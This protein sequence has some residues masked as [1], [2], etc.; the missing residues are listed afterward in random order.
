MAK[1][2][3]SELVQEIFIFLDDRGV[4]DASELAAEMVDELL[5]NVTSLESVVKDDEGEDEEDEVED[6]DIE[7]DEDDF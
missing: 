5:E 7:E 2:S 6:E 3:K 1:V 4:D